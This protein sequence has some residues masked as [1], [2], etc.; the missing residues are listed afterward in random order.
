[1]S[2]QLTAAQFKAVLPSGYKG[3]ISSDLMDNINKML[4]DPNMGETFRENIVSYTHVMKEGRFK[5]EDY[6]SAVRYISFKLMGHTNFEA[7]VKTFPDR[8]QNYLNNNVSTRDI[9]SY[10]SSYNKNRLV[11][12]IYEQ[13]LIPT[14]VLNADIF[15]KAINVQADLMMNA[16]SEKVK[17]DAANSL[18]NHLKKPEANKIELNVGMNEGGVI[19]E[20]RELTS[21]LA[22][23]QRQLIEG[24]VY[25]AQ[26]VAHTRLTIEGESERVDD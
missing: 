17:C 20:L 18:L 9:H 11:N 7:Y 13:T 22:A 5:L 10:V 6:L 14:H 24:G 8:Y 3:N 1:M 25:S 26:E 19:T 4:A 23:K 21:Q 12:L 2:T 15:Q 16:K